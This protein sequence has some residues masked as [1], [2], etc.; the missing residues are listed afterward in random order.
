MRYH[1]GWPHILLFRS[2]LEL[3][4]VHEKILTLT[5]LAHINPENKSKIEILIKK[6]YTS[7]LLFLF[8]YFCKNNSLLRFTVIC[9]TGK[10]TFIFACNSIVWKLNQWINQLLPIICQQH[11]PN[12]IFSFVQNYYNKKTCKSWQV[13][14]DN[15]VV[16]AAH[17]IGTELV[18][19]HKSKLGIGGHLSNLVWR[20]MVLK[21]CKKY[22][23]SIITWSWYVKSYT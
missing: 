14:V 6:R 22:D 5:E 8:R 20:A 9:Y 4:Q 18:N 17:T 2:I 1:C 12:I 19:K 11:L 3:K 13:I 10:F 15:R 21:V 23:N 16:I 7:N